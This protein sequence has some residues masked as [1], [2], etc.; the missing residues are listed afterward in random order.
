[1][2]SVKNRSDEDQEYFRGSVQENG[3]NHRE[4]WPCGLVHLKEHTSLKAFWFLRTI[5]ACVAKRKLFRTRL[6]RTETSGLVQLQ[7]GEPP[8]PMKEAVRDATGAGL[9]NARRCA[10]PSWGRGHSGA[11]AAL[12][13]SPR[14]YRS[15][16]GSRQCGLRLFAECGTRT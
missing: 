8:A 5:E 15:A 11:T 9:S 1:M 12:R 14:N 13:L 4:D 2:H 3:F 6:A 16:G 7:A 10:S